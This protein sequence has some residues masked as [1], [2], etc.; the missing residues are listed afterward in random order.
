MSHH[1][2]TL[3][4]V[5][6]AVLWHFVVLRSWLW[7]FPFLCAG[8][9]LMQR[10]KNKQLQ[11]HS[12]IDDSGSDGENTTSV[13]MVMHPELELTSQPT[14]ETQ[15]QMEQLDTRAEFGF[16]LLNGWLETYVRKSG[17]HSLC[18]VAFWSEMS[19]TDRHVR[20][21]QRDGKCVLRMLCRVRWAQR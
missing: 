5:Y 20:P 17:Q 4:T 7:L 15:L 11:L 9:A 3:S 18:S 8:T 2:M 1:V 14:L 12:S 21:I 10:M 19:N 13:D 6:C 16:E